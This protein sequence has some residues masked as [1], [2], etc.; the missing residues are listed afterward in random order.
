MVLK[1]N[2]TSVETFST[3]RI[4]ELTMSRIHTA[5]K[6]NIIHRP[7]KHLGAMLFAAAIVAVSAVTVFA[8][9][10]K[11]PADVAIEMNAHVLAEMLEAAAVSEAKAAETLSENGETTEVI[12]QAEINQRITSGKY[13]FTLLGILTTDEIAELQSSIRPEDKGYTYVVAAIENA[14]GTPFDENTYF[15]PLSENDRFQVTPLISG[16]SFKDGGEFWHGAAQV[17]ILDGV[18]YQIRCVDDVEIFADRGVK[19]AIH[20]AEGVGN[21]AYSYDEEKADWVL[22]PD[23]EGS[24]VMFDLPLD[25]SKANAEKAAQYF[26]DLEAQKNAP[27]PSEIQADLDKWAFLEDEMKNIDWADAIVIE[28]SQKTVT[29]DK[30]GFVIYEFYSDEHGGGRYTQRYS[31]IFTSD[32]PQSV[33][34]NVSSGAFSVDDVRYNAVRYTLEGDGT[35]IAEM[36]SPNVKNNPNLA[37]YPAYSVN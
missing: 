33:V 18:L 1:K 3:A 12:K 29:V 8:I 37:K 24:A 25:Q 6:T 19:L 11:R 2:N 5:Q 31:D 20:T 4:K 36:I 7:I 9:T 14:D 35:I 23:F 17:Q 16:I 26:A 22:N 34:T 21:D 30:N 28:D 15:D 32:E 10:Y 27:L 13:T